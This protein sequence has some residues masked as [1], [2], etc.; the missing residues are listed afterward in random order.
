MVRLY[1]LNL[2]LGD[3]VKVFLLRVAQC[4]RQNLLVVEGGTT[5]EVRHL[6]IVGTICDGLIVHVS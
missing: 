4:V 6:C 1:A 3:H 5:E 2:Y